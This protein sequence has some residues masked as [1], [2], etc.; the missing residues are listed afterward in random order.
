MRSHV[1]SEPRNLLEIDVGSFWC[2]FVVISSAPDAQKE[3]GRSSPN[4]GTEG[5]DTAPDFRIRARRSRAAL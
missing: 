1:L 3:A 5:G 2:G 4:P